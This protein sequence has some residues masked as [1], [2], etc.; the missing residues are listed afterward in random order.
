MSSE[1]KT[2]PHTPGPWGLK[3]RTQ[4]VTVTLGPED[5]TWADDVRLRL[6]GGEDAA[7]DAVTVA[8]AR[9]IASAPLLLAACVEAHRVLAVVQDMVVINRDPGTQE[10]LDQLAA[11]IAKAGG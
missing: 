5:A 4:S 10:C 8:N 3:V 2:A 6:Y 7:A 1:S 9:L 11:V